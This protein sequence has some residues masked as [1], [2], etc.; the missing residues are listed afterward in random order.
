VGVVVW[1]NDG[2]GT[3]VKGNDDSRCSSDG[4]VFWLERGQNEMR[5]SGVESGQG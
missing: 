3:A 2:R 4:V 1:R 5:L